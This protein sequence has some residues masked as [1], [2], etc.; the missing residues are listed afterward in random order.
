MRASYRHS[1]WLGA[2]LALLASSLV[3]PAGCGGDVAIG[4]Q[5]QDA[6]GGADGSQS[7]DSS[8]SGT[9]GSGRDSAM[10]SSGGGDTGAG[11]DV[12]IGDDAPAVES[13]GPDGCADNIFCSSGSHWDPQLC[14]CVPDD[15]GGPDTGC[16][17]R[18]CP[19][20]GYWD[21][22]LC[23]CVYNDG[24]PCISGRGGVCGGFTSNPCQCASGLTCVYEAGIAD[25]PGTCQ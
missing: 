24:G 20:G 23:M 4:E 11:G 5:D 13:G 14:T 21:S 17:V 16:A 3:L 1:A 6:A 22:Q 19:I 15:A 18:P 8:S 2:V 12:S 7:N 10:G 9:D 25:L